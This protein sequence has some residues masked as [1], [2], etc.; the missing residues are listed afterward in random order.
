M[1]ADEKAVLLLGG[2]WVRLFSQFLGTYLV[3]KLCSQ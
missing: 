2:G 3:E 1:G